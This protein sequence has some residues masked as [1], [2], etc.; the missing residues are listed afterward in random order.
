MAL[1]LTQTT[2]LPEESW[3]SILIA[4][5]AM[6]PGDHHHRKAVETDDLYDNIIHSTMENALC[7]YMAKERNKA[8]RRE[9][10]AQETD[11]N[12]L[13]EECTRLKA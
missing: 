6:R 13:Q 8:L 12:L 11:K 2:S 7:V 9:F 4:K 3:L 10:E 1:A 5:N